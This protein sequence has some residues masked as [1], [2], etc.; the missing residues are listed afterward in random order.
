[1]V[2]DTPREAWTIRRLLS[3]TTTYLREN[4]ADSPRLDAEILLAHALKC[5]RIE[6]Y[7]TFDAVPTENER[8]V[9]RELVKRRAQ[10]EPVAYLVGRKEFFSLSFQVTKDVLIPRPET[11]LVISC[12][13][14]HVEESSRRE[15]SIVDVGT[16]SGI[17][18][19]C[20]AKFL[21]QAR[22][23]AID[24]SEAA[25]N[26]ARRNATAHGVEE[27]ITF[28]QGDLLAPL[29]K[30]LRF[31]FII[32]NPPYI[33]ADEMENLAPEVRDHEPAAALLAG[34]R[35]TEFIERLLCESNHRLKDGG[36]LIFEISPMIADAVEK[37]MAST[38]ELAP[39]PLVKDLSGH[40]RVAVL[41]R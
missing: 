2:D 20:G 22:I 25:L 14:D 3:W 23:H 41:R 8:A 24:T 26:V 35:G 33:S 39:S 30:E 9:F 28:H 37:L 27:H 18:A 40:P 21:P 7:T 12:L 36:Y 17:L 4:A 29:E 15:C 11:E 6:L 38:E 16:G 1:M 31:D 13:L 19:I 34:P 5:E 10:H 32:S